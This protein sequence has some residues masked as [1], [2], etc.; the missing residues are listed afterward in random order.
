MAEPD[1][2]GAHPYDAVT[3]AFADVAERAVEYADV[4]RSAIT[5][6]A[7]GAYQPEDALVDVQALWGLAIRDA[8]R[9]GSALVEAVAPL[10]PK[11]A[12]GGRGDADPETA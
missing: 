8:I 6:N 3:A 10:I 11:D 2:E 7:S 4:W 12:F 9:V 1:A 5:R